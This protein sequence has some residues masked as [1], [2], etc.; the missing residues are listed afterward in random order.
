[1]AKILNALVKSRLVMAQ[2]GRNGGCKAART[3]SEITVLDVIQAVDPIRR[4]ASCP[5]GIASHGANL[6]PLHRKL[7]DAAAS[8][9]CAFGSTT[10]FDLLNDS[11][12]IK[13]LCDSSRIYHVQGAA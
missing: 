13:P 11:S 7:D 1:M 9:E 5:L 10:I 2:R 8:I 12:E 6:C 3:A 4:I